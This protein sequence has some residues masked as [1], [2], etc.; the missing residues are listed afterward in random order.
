M[1]ALIFISGGVNMLLGF[2][3]QAE[4]LGSKEYVIPVF[5][6][7]PGILMAAVGVALKLGGGVALLLGYKASRA[8]GLLVIY[9]IL[10][11]LMF[12]VGEGELTNALKNLAV[13]GGLLYIMAFGAG[14]WGVCSKRTPAPVGPVE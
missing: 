2:S 13:I 4:F 10:A 8:A 7:L 9:V 14:A 5:A 12:H 11:T 6:M 1:L 3:G